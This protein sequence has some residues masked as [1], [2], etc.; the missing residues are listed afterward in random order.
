MRARPCEPLLVLEM[1][2]CMMALV[3]QLALAC[4]ESHLAHVRSVWADC[5]LS[6]A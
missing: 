5:S 3:W 4:P 1:L 6:K 2:L